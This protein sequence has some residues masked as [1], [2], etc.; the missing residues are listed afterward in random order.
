MQLQD[1]PLNGVATVATLAL[2]DTCLT[3]YAKF[4]FLES[5]CWCTNSCV[6]T[7]LVRYCLFWVCGRGH[8]RWENLYIHTSEICEQV[9]VNTSSSIPVTLA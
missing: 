9:I 8:V 2:N 6:V 7:E 4:K 5:V 1:Y 3:Y